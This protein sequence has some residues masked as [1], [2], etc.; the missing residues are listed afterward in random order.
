MLGIIK[1]I[2]LRSLNGAETSK[3]M[4]IFNDMTVFYNGNSYKIKEIFNV[5]DKDAAVF[6][7][8]II[9]GTKNAKVGDQLSYV[10]KIKN[11]K[12]INTAKFK[13]AFD[14]DGWDL[15]GVAASGFVFATDMYSLYHLNEKFDEIEEELYAIEGGSSGV[16]KDA[17][18]EV[19]NELRQEYIEQFANEYIVFAAKTT[20]DLAWGKLVTFLAKKNPYAFL[21]VASNSI[22]TCLA[23]TDAVNKGELTLPC[24]VDAMNDTISKIE[25][26]YS[27]FMLNPSNELYYEL[28][29]LFVT[30]KFQ[31]ELGAEVYMNLSMADYN[32]YLKRF[33]RFVNPFDKDDK[34]P[35]TIQGCYD[36]DIEK[37][38][39]VLTWFGFN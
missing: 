19:I 34:M 24:I 10:S 9:K 7:K 22:M 8:D 30:Y 3:Y 29:S 18:S 25:Y 11:T 6:L 16:F 37:L 38:N 15:V 5:A 32:S 33:I 20:S 31:V 2:D 26:T 28:K 21:A 13:S 27:L 17:I 14:V 1:K 39:Y 36:E 4:D 23:N 12:I 35:E